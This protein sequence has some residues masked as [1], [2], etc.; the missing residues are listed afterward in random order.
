MRVCGKFKHVLHGS[1]TWLPPW[2][3]SASRGAGPVSMCAFSHGCIALLPPQVLLFASHSTK[4]TA[5]ELMLCWW[6][7]HDDSRCCQTLLVCQDGRS[8]FRQAGLLAGVPRGTW[9]LLHTLQ[10]CVLCTGAWT[11]SGVMLQCRDVAWNDGQLYR[12]DCVSLVSQ[13]CATLHPQR[14]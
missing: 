1:H 9:Q 12:A 13:G 7:R 6:R 5:L 2:R 4:A 14:V 3:D 8:R 10:C 11:G